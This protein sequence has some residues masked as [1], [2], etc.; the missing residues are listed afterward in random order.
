MFTY[1][2]A[3]RY[4]WLNA[5]ENDISASTRASTEKAGGK[6]VMWRQQ[7]MCVELLVLLYRSLGCG[8]HIKLKTSFILVT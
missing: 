4:P 7:E 2:P 1:P 5:Q 3:C 6:M 8:R